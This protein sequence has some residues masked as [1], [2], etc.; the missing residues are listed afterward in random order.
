L[1]E[2]AS[3]WTSVPAPLSIM[4]TS[5]WLAV[6]TKPSDRDKASTAPAVVVPP[7]LKCEPADVRF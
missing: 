7:G 6:E 5:I 4:M 2:E 1:P 3:L